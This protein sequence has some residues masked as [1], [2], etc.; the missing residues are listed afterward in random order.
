MNIFFLHTNANI[1]AI[2]HADK[3]VIKMI[4]ETLQLLCSAIWM[5]EYETEPPLKLTHKNH[6]CAIWAR[7]S[8]KNWLWLKSLGIAL[9]NEY[10]FRYCKKHKYDEIMRT[11]KAPNIPNIGFTKPPQCMPDEYKRKSFIEAYREYYRCGKVHLLSWSGSK[12]LKVHGSREI[13]EWL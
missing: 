8:R 5:S 2:Y 12:T 9:C 10:T 11:I 4:L 6:P 13:P 7:T 1:C 3:H